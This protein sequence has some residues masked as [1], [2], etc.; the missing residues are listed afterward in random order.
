MVQLYIMA[1][2]IRGKNGEADILDFESMEDLR[3][4]QD[5]IMVSWAQDFIEDRKQAMDKSKGVSSGQLKGSLSQKFD[6]S[7]AQLV[8]SVSALFFQYGR[9]IDMRRLNWGQQRPTSAIESWIQSRGVDNFIRNFKRYRKGRRIPHGSQL[10]N[11][12][13]WGIVKGKLK[14]QKTRRRPWYNK[15]KFYLINQLQD[16]LTDLYADFGIQSAK[17]ALK[18]K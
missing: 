13:A 14:N 17:Q 16:Q 1:R 11:Q 15:G 3:R 10:I 18:K 8:G 4:F 6:A 9:F 5:Q 2:R 12:I 7:D